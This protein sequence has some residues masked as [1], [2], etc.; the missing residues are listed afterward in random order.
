MSSV[1]SFS[2]RQLTAHDVALM[3]AMLSTFGEAFDQEETYGAARPSQ[4]YL[5]RLLGKDDFIAIAALKHESVVGGL[6]AYELQK[7]EQERS[8]IYIYDLAVAAAHR[9][10]GVATA[11][12]EEL[13]KIAVTRGAYVIFVQADIGDVPAIALYEKL[14]VRE[15]VLHFDIAVPQ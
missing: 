10:K 11:L 9:R 15:D 3:E 12:I 6:V 4:A 1:T 2:I 8:E 5:Q 13:Q 14:G 7:F